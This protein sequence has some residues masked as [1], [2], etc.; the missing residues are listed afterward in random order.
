MLLSLFSRAV[1]QANLR[2]MPFCERTDLSRSCL[3]PWFAQPPVLRAGTVYALP[4]AHP[5]G[6]CLPLI[7]PDD[8]EQRALKNLPCELG[9]FLTSA[10]K[11][12][13]NTR[14]F[15]EFYGLIGERCCITVRSGSAFTQRHSCRHIA[16]LCLSYLLRAHEAV[17]LPE[18]GGTAQQNRELMLAPTRHAVGRGVSQPSNP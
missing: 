5:E 3:L 15:G 16:I 10:C 1:L 4:W 12:G 2:D 7:C 13:C 8:R 11:F 9:R 18:V 14:C 6:R 17:V